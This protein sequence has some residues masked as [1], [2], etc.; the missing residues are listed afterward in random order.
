MKLTDSARKRHKREVNA[1]LN[2]I[3]FFIGDQ[4]DRWVDLRTSRST[5]IKADMANILIDR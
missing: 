4:I 5:E 1:K 3:I 2:N